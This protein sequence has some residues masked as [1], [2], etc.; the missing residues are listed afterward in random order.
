M[1]AKTQTQLAEFLQ[2]SIAMIFGGT[3]KRKKRWTLRSTRYLIRS[4]GHCKC[5]FDILRTLFLAYFCMSRD[6]MNISLLEK[7]DLV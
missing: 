3:K 1:I 2:G 7:N 6:P 4:N 5:L